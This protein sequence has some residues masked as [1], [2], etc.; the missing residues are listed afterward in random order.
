MLV[1]QINQFALFL[2]TYTRCSTTGSFQWFFYV[3]FTLDFGKPISFSNNSTRSLAF[4]SYINLIQWLVQ[5]VVLLVEGKLISPISTLQAHQADFIVLA[6]PSP[7]KVVKLANAVIFDVMKLF[8]NAATAPSIRS[9][10]LTT[11]CRC[12]PSLVVLKLLTSLT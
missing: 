5:V 11:M 6:T 7:A 2:A 10:A 1:I 3:R 12:L 9:V 8:L 4:F